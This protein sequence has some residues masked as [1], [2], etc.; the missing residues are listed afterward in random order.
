MTK[1]SKEDVL[2][3]KRG[4]KLFPLYQLD[5]LE[6]QMESSFKKN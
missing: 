1:L 5:K 2:Q 3:T 4:Q 6:E